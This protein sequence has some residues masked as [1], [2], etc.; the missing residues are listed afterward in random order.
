MVAAARNKLSTKFGGSVFYHVLESNDITA[1]EEVQDRNFRDLRYFRIPASRYV[2]TLL[3]TYCEVSHP[4]RFLIFMNMW[5]MP[6]A[7]NLVEE[8]MLGAFSPEYYLEPD[9]T[10]FTTDQIIE[11]VHLTFNEAYI[12]WRYETMLSL[13]ADDDRFFKSYF[14]SQNDEETTNVD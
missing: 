14:S 12:D 8:Q 4:E 1:A 6:E 10:K 3:Y 9:L 11:G 2:H 13:Y 7:D 5:Y